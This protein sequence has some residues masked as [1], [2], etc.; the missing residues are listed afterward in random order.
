MS[1]EILSKNLDEYVKVCNAIDRI[2]TKIDLYREE[3]EKKLEIATEAEKKEIMIEFKNFIEAIKKDKNILI[4]FKTLKQ[5]QN[6]LRL[7]LTSSKCNDC[8]QSINEKNSLD[9][10]D[11]KYRKI[12]NLEESS[13][14]DID[15]TRLELLREKCRTMVDDLYSNN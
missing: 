2:Q 5:K 9:F 3:T 13:I 7:Q 1:N 10:L 8:L 11:E 12:V 4:K 15:I 14:I 6:Q